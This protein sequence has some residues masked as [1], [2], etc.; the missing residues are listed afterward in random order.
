MTNYLAT[1]FHGDRHYEDPSE[2]F[3]WF[4]QY[5]GT[6]DNKM[7]V[8]NFVYYLQADSLADK[9]FEELREEEKGSSMIGPKYLLLTPK[10]WMDLADGPVYS[11]GS[12]LILSLWRVFSIGSV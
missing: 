2:F 10:S 9:W 5:M 11:D 7:K 3:N 12:L 1:P 6:A 4:L 8:W